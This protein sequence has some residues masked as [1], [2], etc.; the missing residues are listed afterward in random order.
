M[1][2]DTVSIV[3][4]ANKPSSYIIQVPQKLQIPILGIQDNQDEYAPLI[5]TAPNFDAQFIVI[6][7]DN[8]ILLLSWNSLGMGVSVLLRF[9]QMW[10]SPPP[11][12]LTTET[13][14]QKCTWKR[15]G[16]R[17]QNCI[18]QNFS[19][20]SILSHFPIEHPNNPVGQGF[21]L[22][23]LQTFELYHSS[24]PF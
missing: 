17:N 18:D 11:P 24:P 14:Q 13:L 23:G 4:A 1:R 8:I 9:I 7:G 2:R 16:T 20:S 15:P 22:G 5:N 19:G 3:I 12:W 21:F 10:K 6:T